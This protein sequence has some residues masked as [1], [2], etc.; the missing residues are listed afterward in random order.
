MKRIL[1]S[2]GFVVLLACG[3]DCG[4]ARAQGIGMRPPKSSEKTTTTKSSTQKSSTS[5]TTTQKSSNSEAGPSW[6]DGTWTYSGYIDTFFGTRM[7]TNSTLT[8]NR[9][10]RTLVFKGDGSVIEQG[11]YSVYDGA[12]HCNSTYFNLDE[13]NHRIEFGNGEYY[14]KR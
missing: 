14:T 3:F 5:K 13:K 2:L 10:N 7:K 4:Q 11:K 8:I 1:I 9:S 12:I 6:I